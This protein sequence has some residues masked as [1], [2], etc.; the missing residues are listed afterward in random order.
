MKFPIQYQATDTG[1][2]FTGLEKF[3]TKKVEDFVNMVFNPT[4]REEAVTLSG[5][6]MDLN[7]S[8]QVIDLAA[9]ETEK[10]ANK[11]ADV[12]ATSFYTLQTGNAFLSVLDACDDKLNLSSLKSPNSVKTLTGNA[13]GNTEPKQYARCNDYGYQQTSIK[14]NNSWNG[15]GRWL[16][17][18]FQLKF[19]A[20]RNIFNFA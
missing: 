14:R 16:N 6:E 7:N 19:S 8:A 20:F 2:W 4:G 15:I 9:R 3:S 12:I 13:E 11:M 10:T 18:M 1:T 5:I 17:Q